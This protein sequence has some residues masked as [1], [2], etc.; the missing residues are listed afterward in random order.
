MTIH[1]MTT[2]QKLLESKLPPENKCFFGPEE[3]L[4][5][6]PCWSTF[7]LKAFPVKWEILPFS[8]EN[9]VTEPSLLILVCHILL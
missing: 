8:M 7:F 9:L 3:T 1:Q 5:Y 2:G 4:L 6:F